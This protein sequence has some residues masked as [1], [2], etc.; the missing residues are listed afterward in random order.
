VGLEAISLSKFISFSLALICQS[1]ISFALLVGL[2]KRHYTRVNVHGKVPSI[3]SIPEY[4]T[5]N[6]KE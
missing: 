6:I 4:T 2:R 3:H 1:V 5:I